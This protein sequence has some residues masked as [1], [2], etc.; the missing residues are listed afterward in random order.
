MR[1]LAAFIAEL[2]PV[3]GGAGRRRVFRGKTME[4][5]KAIDRRAFIK[6]AAAGAAGLA[7][8]GKVGGQ[9]PGARPLKWLPREKFV[10]RTLGKTGLRLPVVSMGI[11]HADNPALIRVAMDAGVVYFDT[12]YTYQQGKNEE[13]LGK[14]TRE[15]PGNSLIISTK[16][17]GGKKTSYENFLWR[18]NRSL[19]RLE[20]EYVDIL[21]LH[22][23]M[24]RDHALREPILRALRK[25]KEE[26]KARFVGVSAHTRVPDVIHAAVDSQFYDVVMAAYT[27][28]Q[29]DHKKVEEAIDRAGEA[30]LGVITMKVFS[31]VFLNRENTAMVDSKAALKWVL[32]NPNVHSVMVG[33]YTFDQLAMNLSVM[34]DL[35]L[36]EEEKGRLE[37]QGAE[38]GLYCQGCEQ[39]L[40]QCPPG[41]PIPDLMRAY[42]YVYGYH[43]LRSAYDLV[44]SL[45]LP[46]AVCRDCEPCPVACAHGF[47]VAERIKDVLR[48]REV[49]SDF[50]A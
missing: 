50:I 26:G 1:N 42:M 39:C 40:P 33:M 34:A 38:V 15:R 13:L 14:L 41:L 43:Q 48:L 35:I 24:S 6:T 19:Q 47:N 17:L 28:K 27:F 18:F 8:L 16:V 25:L 36:T 23:A 4:T 29:R 9:A 32:R 11:E 10:Y 21:Y 45:R 44:T 31:G 22:G 20:M 12:A 46:D 3:A 2:N 30:G 49:P 37:E 7:F 5:K